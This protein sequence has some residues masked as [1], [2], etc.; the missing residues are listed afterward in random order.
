MNTPAWNWRVVL[1]Q[2]RNPLNIGAA[3]RA[4]ANFGFRELMVVNPYEPTWRETRSAVGAGDVVRS[5]RAVPALMDAVGDANLAVGTT[6]GSRRHLARE[7]VALAELPDWLQCHRP[8]R[9]A[10]RGRT[11][12]RAAL[13]FGSEKT[14]LSNDEMSHCQVLVRIPTSPGCPSMNLGQAVAVCC[15]ELARQGVATNRATGARIHRSHPAAQQSLEHLVDRAARVLDAA[16]YLKPKSRAATLLK[17]RQ[18]LLKLG[19]TEYDARIVGGVL[20]QIEW[21]LGLLAR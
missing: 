12:L 5:A 11:V 7:L 3:A 13:L 1:V 15:Y 17:L 8:T 16:G 10:S 20:A 19:L 9:P 18:L 4:M 14:G 6:S 2:P 21:K